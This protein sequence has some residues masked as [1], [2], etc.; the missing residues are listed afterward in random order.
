[1][2]GGQT[3][4]YPPNYNLS[5]SQTFEENE[6]GAD[7]QQPDSST[8]SELPTADDG[9]LLAESDASANEGSDQTK[10]E[11]GLEEGGGQTVDDEEMTPQQFLAPY[12]NGYDYAQFY[13][14]FYYPGCVMAPF[15]VV[16]NGKAIV[17]WKILKR[18]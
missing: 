8:E 5:Q 6:E 1:M 9:G 13:N 14:N 10:T 11:G 18:F 4:I 12:A 2:N 16:E 15:P 7:V 17:K 3:Y